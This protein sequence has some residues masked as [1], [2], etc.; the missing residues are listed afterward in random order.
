MVRPSSRVY[1]AFAIAA[2]VGA[3]VFVIWWVTG[4]PPVRSEPAPP[5]AASPSSTVSAPLEFTLPRGGSL[6]GS[7]DDVDEAIARLTQA[8][9]VRINRSTD[10]VEPWLAESWTASADNLTYTFKLRPNV[11]WSDGT[12]LDVEDVAAS[13]TSSPPFGGLPLWASKPA[14]RV[15]DPLTIELR[16]PEPFAPALRVLDRQPIRPGQPSSKPVGLG[17]FVLRDA[18]SSGS[19]RRAL[20]RN[21]HYWRQAPDGYPYPYLDELRFEAGLPGQHDFSDIPVAADD[22]E[23]LR[24]AELSGEGRLF[25]L[26]VGLDA[27]A[28]WF[29]P[30]PLGAQDKPWLSTEAFRLAISA[31]V[32]RR[33]Y[34][35]QVFFGAC[36]PI[37]TPVTPAN[38]A[39]FNP[40]L[41][42][43]RGNPQVARQML[44]EL[45]LRDRNGDGIL[46]DAAR[47]SVRFSLMIRR[48]VPSSSRAATFLAET[49]R[50]VG[51][52]VDVVTLDAATLRAR[53]VK[54]VYEAIYDRIAVRD[55][56]PAMNLDFWLSSGEAHPWNPARQK[57]LSEGRPA[58]WER[59][60]DQLMLKNATTFDR[61]Q[62]LQAFVD[63]QRIYSQHMPALFFGAPHVRIYT[64]TRVLNAT[65]SSLRPHLLWNAENLAVLK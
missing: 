19:G 34:C 43:G 35:K 57:S 44:G 27:D 15:I 22:V 16:F 23:A 5:E 58:D 65:P 8:P 2:L 12:P 20:V 40:D 59:Q 24:K 61:I 18:G 47:R 50:A 26:G 21:P 9:L 63:V 10:R 29:A 53:R 11:L 62:R 60:I 46:D 39:W 38:T 25:D 41:P 28:L 7:T 42:L 64:S 51:V 17:P 31:A 55:T 36:D 3:V 14:A 45:G 56:D 54:G 6:T 1:I 13:L 52:G 4:A 30:E 48:D 49:L 37:S 33:E 32:D